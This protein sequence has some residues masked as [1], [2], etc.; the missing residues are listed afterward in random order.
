LKDYEQAKKYMDLAFIHE[1]EPSGVMLEHYG[2]IL[3]Q[4]GNKYEAISFWK[5]ADSTT[6]G[7]KNLSRKIKEGKYYE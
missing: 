4:L 5:K 2:D 6:E 3:Y 7:S 1:T